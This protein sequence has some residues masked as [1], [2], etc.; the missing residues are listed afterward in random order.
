MSELA[1]LIADLGLILSVA[2]VTTVVSKMVRQPVVLGYIVAGFLVGPH[3]AFLPTIADEESL[4]T[5]SE[6]GVIFLLFSLGLEFSFRKL[7]KVGGTATVTALVT[8]G[9]M[10]GAGFITGKLMG[11]S[12]MDSIF[13]GGIL[14][15]S[16]TTIIYRAFDELGLKT[17][18]FARVVLGVLVVE[19][20]VA[21]LLLVLLST[22]AVSRDF[23]GGAL[24]FELGKLVFFL[25]LWFV[26]GI[27]IIPSLLKRTRKWMNDETLL[28]VSVAL[29]LVMVHA[30]VVVGFSAPLGAFVMGSLLAETTKAERIEHLV[31]PVKDLFGAIFFVS[32]GMMI[33]PQV[34]REHWVP[35]LVLSAVTLIGQP[36]SST[37]GAV[38]AGQP[39]PIAVRA[40][41]SL[42]QI[43]EF[44]FIIATLGLS[45]HVTSDLLYPIAVAV[46]AITTF[47]T[48]YMIKAGAPMQAFVSRVLPQRWRESLG[49]Y[50]DQS[51]QVRATSEWNR[52]VRAYLRNIA[53][54]GIIAVAILILC[55]RYLAGLLSG[56]PEGDLLTG[57]IALLALLPSLWAIAVRRMERAAYRRLWLNRRLLRGPLVA[58]E[59]LRVCTA[60]MLLLVV[61]VLFF[62]SVWA[63]WAVPLAVVVTLVLFRQRLQGFYHRVEQHFLLNLNQR[64][65][66]EQRKVPAMAPWD[67][68]LAKVQVAENSKV[69]GHSLAELALRERY[70]VNIALIE[71]EDRTIAVPDRSERLFPG[72]DLMVIGTDEQLA[73]LN[74]EL[75]EPTSEARAASTAEVDVELLKFEIGAHSPLVGLSVRASRVKEE[76]RG[77]VVG[78]ERREERLLN[79]D[80]AM[81]FEPG[82]VIWVTGDGGL[83]RNYMS[84]KADR[85]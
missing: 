3:V 58:L 31:K 16:S 8:V 34:L 28:V 6:I 21:I 63:S 46:S 2:A 30:A 52:L 1:P 80:G 75:N 41:M 60:L 55:Q 26:V 14:S 51:G 50:S 11:W 62:P 19:D 45:L 27:F 33:D 20:L 76:A 15:I 59:L 73:Q 44:S 43:G 10:I 64:A 53:L 66:R 84:G 48:P 69:A 22:L 72:D 5:W 29:C 78:I 24:L 4:R 79:P 81:V 40:G 25:V 74:K 47:T 77:L 49:R 38:V 39:L 9:F 85:A 61:V 32:V 65:Y 35:V 70:G 23:A 67:M 7:M 12:F 56:M 37:F 68:H 57:L 83:I 71:R 36:L 17:A 54:H 42:S 82:D 13:L 18:S